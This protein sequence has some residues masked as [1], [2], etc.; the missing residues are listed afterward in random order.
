MEINV[1]TITNT[2]NDCIID[3][4]QHTLKDYVP[5]VQT[6]APGIIT[7][8]KDKIPSWTHGLA[9][10]DSISPEY[11]K[12]LI[13]NDKTLLKFESLAHTQV[14]RMQ[15]EEFRKNVANLI[16]IGILLYLP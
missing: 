7:E 6:D 4:A 2:I 3:L 10:D 15:L 16:V 5:Q 9:F 12:V 8:I 11:L 13:Q 1:E 14:N